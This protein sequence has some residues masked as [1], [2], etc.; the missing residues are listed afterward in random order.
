VCGLVQNHK[1]KASAAK[2]K[3]RKTILGESVIIKHTR[4]D[5]YLSQFLGGRYCA[6]IT[7]PIITVAQIRAA[8]TALKE[9]GEA[10]SEI[11]DDKG[12]MLGKV[13]GARRV[14]G[15][16]STK[17]KGGIHYRGAR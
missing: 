9:A 15:A 16:T 4:E 2:R 7:V 12:N 6:R 8:A 17:L 3:R 14:I 1:S 5:E 10:L 11:A 13:L